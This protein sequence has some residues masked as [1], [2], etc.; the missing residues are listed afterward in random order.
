MMKFDRIIAK[1]EALLVERPA[2]TSLASQP[3][4]AQ[5]HHCLSKLGQ[6]G[7]RRTGK[8]LAVRTAAERIKGR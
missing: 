5:E 2:R 1:A 7:L 8:L 6:A 3:S 4:C